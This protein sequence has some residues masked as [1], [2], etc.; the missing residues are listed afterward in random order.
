MAKDPLEEQTVPTE[1]LARELSKILGCS[2]AHRVGDNWGPCE[3]HG[4]LRRLIRMGNPAFREWK[5]RQKGQR[6]EKGL[7]FKSDNKKGTYKS[8]AEAERQAKLV[9]CNGAHM[10]SQG[11]WAPC[12]TPE[13][14][15]AAKAHSSNGGSPVL[16]RAESSKRTFR[17]DK[18]WEK[19]RERGP[20]GIETIDGGGLVSA[21]ALQSDSFTPTRGMIAEAKRGLEWRKE[22]KRG[23][24]AVGIARARDIANNKNLPYATVK[25]MKAFFDRHQSDSSA[26][27]F[28]PGEKGFPSNGRIAHALWGGDSGYVWAKSIVKRVEGKEKIDDVFVEVKAAGGDPKT[29]AKPSER[30]SGSSTNKPGSASSG[31][32]DIE[33]T[34]QIERALSDKV[35]QHNEN[36]RKRGKDELVVSTGTLKA[37]WRRGA[38][39]F[40]TSHRPK[41]GRQQWAM[42]RV[43]AFLYLV[44][45]EKPKNPKYITDN[46]LLPKKH[47]RS[48][49][50]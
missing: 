34:P 49:K 21:K 18:E 5:K 12:A 3:S 35:K 16:R 44:A 2:G 40:S 4:D 27:G 24:T 46:D 25:R 1:K 26:E 6:Q 50:K 17:R 15:N 8:R 7:M 38:G 33:L 9:G 13:D 14:F 36:M 22:H 31:K 47:K 29:P 28:R 32:N 43:N 23:G 11:V 41:M 42:G 10:I 39:A 37:V 20:R 19:L 30:I 48:T 45:N